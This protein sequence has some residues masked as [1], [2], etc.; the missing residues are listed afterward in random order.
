M[1]SRSRCHLIV[2]YTRTRKLK[3]RIDSLEKKLKCQDTRR[4]STTPSSALSALRPGTLSG[5]GSTGLDSTF[6]NNIWWFLIRSKHNNLMNYF[7]HD[8]RDL[9]RAYV[10]SCEKFFHNLRL[11]KNKNKSKASSIKLD[12]RQ[13]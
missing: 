3:S 5:L 12:K 6:Q 8:K 2:Q 4:Q 11:K 10:K 1:A 13:A 7:V 9:S